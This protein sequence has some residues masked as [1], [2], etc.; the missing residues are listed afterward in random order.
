[1]RACK[2]VKH[3]NDSGSARL[4]DHGPCV[5]F[6]VPGVHH[7]RAAKLPRQTEL[8]G[9]CAALFE[10]RRVVVVVVESALTNGDCAI[11]DEL[12]ECRYVS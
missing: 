4:A 11:S 1:M 10:T 2:A 12:A 6:G 5:L 8:F 9:E 7:D 3:S